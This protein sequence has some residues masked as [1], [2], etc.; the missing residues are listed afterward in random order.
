VAEE[1]GL[2]TDEPVSL[3]HDVGSHG[4]VG[5]EASESSGADFFLAV[6][7]I[8]GVSNDSN[9]LSTVDFAVHK[10]NSFASVE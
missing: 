8:D 9:G 10:C 7:V 5:R 6:G 4:V 2:S 3:S 1:V